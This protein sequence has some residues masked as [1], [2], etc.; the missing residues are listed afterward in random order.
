MRIIRISGL[1]LNIGGALV[2][3]L[4]GLPISKLPVQWTLSHYEALWSYSGFSALV[5]GF[6]LQLFVEVWPCVRRLFS[7]SD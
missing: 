4:W 7:R 2:V 5:A 3:G 1:L 6:A